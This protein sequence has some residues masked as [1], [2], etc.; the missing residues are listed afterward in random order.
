LLPVAVIQN[1]STPE[2]KI[3]IGI[4]DT[5]AEI[6]EDKRITAPALLVFGDV[7]SLH[8]QFQPIRDFYEIIAEEY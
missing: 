1:G 7:V 4:V 3:A 6:V 8:P 2:E 5:I